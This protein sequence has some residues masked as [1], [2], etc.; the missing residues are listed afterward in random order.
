[1]EGHA[2]LLTIIANVNTHLDLFAHHRLDRRLSLLCKF[3]LIDG[4][5]PLLTEQQL[6]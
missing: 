1:M 3:G 2:R 4:L 5:T 6:G